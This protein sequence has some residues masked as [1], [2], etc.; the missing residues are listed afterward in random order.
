MVPAT[1]ALGPSEPASGGGG[2]EAD[3][4]GPPNGP[5]P[6]T[7]AGQEA[8]AG[9]GITL[10]E[11]SGA[12]FSQE[13]LDNL[14]LTGHDGNPVPQEEL[15][16]LVLR[17]HDGNPVPHEE[18]D[19]LLME[20]ASAPNSGSGLEH[21]TSFCSGP[22]SGSGSGSA[23]G[24]G[25]GSGSQTAAAGLIAPRTAGTKSSKSKAKS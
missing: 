4:E 23:S 17:G 5:P 1:P 18:L 16:N 10:A 7:P 13:E 25:S 12:E 21:Q 3:I 24:S 14:V 20:P 11:N 6:A 22:G 8:H 2:G 19:D 15:D 9:D